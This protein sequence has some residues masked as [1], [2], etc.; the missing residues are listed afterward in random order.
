MKKIFLPAV[1]IAASILI[2]L[3]GCKPKNAGNAAE[4]DAASRVYVPPGKYDEL[5]NFV[6]G[7]FS[8][9]VSVYGIPSGRL[10]RVIPV[11]S[12]DPE[13]GYGY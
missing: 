3:A 13:S 8:G 4:G 1:I 9:Q 7:G 5:Y 11:F 6:S 10:F 2:G 12:N